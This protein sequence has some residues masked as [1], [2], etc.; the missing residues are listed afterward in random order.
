MNIS[1]MTLKHKVTIRHN[2]ETPIQ[3]EQIELFSMAIVLN[4][5][6]IQ[7]VTGETNLEQMGLYV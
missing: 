6:S 5:R 3:W 4:T 1:I 7:I 2:L